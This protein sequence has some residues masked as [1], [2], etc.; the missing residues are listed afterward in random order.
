M[1]AQYQSISGADICMYVYVLPTRYD[2]ESAEAEA[3]RTDHDLIPR[4]QLCSSQH[5]HTEAAASSL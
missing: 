2:I 4:L 5:P 1:T 3:E